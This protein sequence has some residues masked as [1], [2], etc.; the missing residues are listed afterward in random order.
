MSNK[1]TIKQLKD[2]LEKELESY[3][4]ITEDEDPEERF[5]SYEE[6]VGYQNALMHVLYLIEEE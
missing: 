2:I 3:E 6:S 1:I 4:N 5:E